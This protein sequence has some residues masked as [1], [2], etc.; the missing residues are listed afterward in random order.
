MI[1][2]SACG[3]ENAEGQ[4][5]CSECGSPLEI[6]CPSCG[7][8]W[9]AT[10]KFCGEC[11]TALHG[12]QA[13]PPSATSPGTAD[14]PVTDELRWA[15]VL[16]VDLVGSTA[17]SEGAAPEDVRELMSGYFD[18]A[19]TVV[20]RYGGE[21]EKFV[22]DAVV[23]V[24]GGSTAHEDDAERAVRAALE[25]LETVAEYG[26]TRSLELRARGGVVTG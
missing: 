19:K 10:H 14:R 15:S 7:A 11:G 6:T 23:A 18:R 2:C 22:G 13:M 20:A 12:T 25:I 26:A 9:A 24:W 8:T 4:H 1:A 16:F 17:L 21:V 3:A 5:F